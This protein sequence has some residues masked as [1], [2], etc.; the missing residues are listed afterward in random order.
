[1]SLFTTLA[2]I[3][4]YIAIALITIAVFPELVVLFVLLY[5]FDRARNVVGRLF[6]LISVV[7]S[8]LNP[9]WTFR[10]VGKLPSQTPQHTVRI[11]FSLEVNTEKSAKEE[12]KNEATDEEPMD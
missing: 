2:T 10:V 9:L 5:P 7:S 1:M 6:R 4:S 12:E 3:W 11:S 8:K